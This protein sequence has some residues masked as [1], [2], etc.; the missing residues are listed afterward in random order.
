MKGMVMQEGE[1]RIPP[2]QAGGKAAL[3]PA[4]PLPLRAGLPRLHHLLRRRPRPLQAARATRSPWSKGRGNAGARSAEGG[5]TLGSAAGTPPEGAVTA[6]TH[7][8]RRPPEA[9]NSL[10]RRKRASTPAPAPSHRLP[11]LLGGLEARPSQWFPA[12][13]PGRR[14]RGGTRAK[15]KDK[16]LEGRRSLGWGG[17]TVW[18]G[19]SP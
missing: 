9:R 12:P 11:G 4:G 2:E 6:S 17:A 5:R 7:P 18:G 3:E 15:G 10:R 14:R 19:Q 1:P 8:P 13:Q 16:A